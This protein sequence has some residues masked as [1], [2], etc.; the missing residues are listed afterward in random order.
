MQIYNEEN[1]IRIPEN[2]TRVN[3]HITNY[4]FDKKRTPIEN[5]KEIIFH[6]KITHIERAA[7]RDFSHLK[8]VIIPDSVEI[9][10]D[11]AFEHCY[12]I[13]FLSIGNGVKSIG[14]RAFRNVGVLNYKKNVPQII[15]GESVKIV[16]SG[17]FE[18]TKHIKMFAVS[19][20][21]FDRLHFHNLESIE[22]L[23]APN[24][25]GVTS[26][27]KD[28]NARKTLKLN[29]DENDNMNIINR[30]INL[31]NYNFTNFKFPQ[32]PILGPKVKLNN[33]IFK[34][35]DMT[36]IRVVDNNF[37]IFKMVDFKTYP[38][39]IYPPGMIEYIQTTKNN[40]LK[41]TIKE[42][43][44]EILK[45]KLGP[46]L[47]TNNTFLL[48]EALNGV[49]KKPRTKTKTKQK[50]TTKKT[51]KNNKHNI[52]NI[53]TNPNTFVGKKVRIKSGRF[54]GEEGLVQRVT[55]KK[56]YVRLDEDTFTCIFKHQL[57][58]LT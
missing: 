3:G 20:T 5:I 7:F 50:K 18:N 31:S 32:I 41:R 10:E 29:G 27:I 47:N 56:A 23:V 57:E 39:K 19:S 2:V 1:V 37:S 24:G 12:F 46:Y 26:N 51:V 35:A 52:S 6:D 45:Y 13:Y 33:T 53:N 43:P 42:I 38:P 58:V 40:A 22:L 4:L 14:E 28:I 54:N 55:P 21:H 8:R 49:K 30:D 36:N 34:D 11:F 15:I 9:I 17:N 44:S 16:S 48:S 25:F